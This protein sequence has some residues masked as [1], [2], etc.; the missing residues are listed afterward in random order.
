MKAAS[1]IL[2]SGNHFQCAL[3]D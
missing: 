1:V 2:L 3:L